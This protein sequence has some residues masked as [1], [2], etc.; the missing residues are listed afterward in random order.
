MCNSI[1]SAIASGAVKLN[2][3]SLKIGEERS[4]CIKY[5][6]TLINLRI[7]HKEFPIGENKIKS[8]KGIY[9]ISD[10][11]YAFWFKFVFPNTDSI[12]G[13]NGEVIFNKIVLPRLSDYI[14]KP[15]ETICAE[16]MLRK[17]QKNELPFQFVDFGRWWGTD[18]EL[19]IQVEIDFVATFEKKIIL[20]ECKWRNDLRDVSELKKLLEKIKL[21]S[22]YTEQYF[23]LFSKISFSNECKKLAKDIKNVQ[24]VEIEDMI[25]SKFSCGNLSI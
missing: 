11:F 1:I 25:S 18:N 6:Q 21:F 4:K 24:L 2:D 5:L 22:N 8:R 20:G 17:N 3:I 12:E 15:F 23:Y 19:K 13:G 10:N 14:G 9:K 16:Y 7:I